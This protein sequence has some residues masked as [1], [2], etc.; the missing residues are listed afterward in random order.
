MPSISAAASSPPGHC[1]SVILKAK[2]D[3][4]FSVSPKGK[5]SSIVGCWDGYFSVEALRRG[6]SRVLAP[7]ITSGTR[8]GAAAPST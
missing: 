8:N 1:T 2:A 4:Y 3:S 6:V 7:I 5:R